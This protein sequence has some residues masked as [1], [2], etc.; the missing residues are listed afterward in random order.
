LRIRKKGKFVKKEYADSAIKIW[1]PEIIYEKA[2]I[3]YKHQIIMINI[4]AG[5]NL[6]L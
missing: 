2:K 5:I 4:N 6:R 3:L 1:E